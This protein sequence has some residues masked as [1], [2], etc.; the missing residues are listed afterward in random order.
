V[1]PAE[2]W[3]ALTLAAGQSGLRGARTALVRMGSPEAVLGAGAAEL[4]TRCGLK[5]E[6]A[7]RIANADSPTFRIESRLIAEHG[8]RLVPWD[9]PAYPEALRD[10]PSAP[11]LLYVQG[12]WPDGGSA[13]LGSG[14]PADDSGLVPPDRA[15][16]AGSPVPA[17]GSASSRR[18]APAQGAKPARGLTLAVVG[19]R[20][21]TGYGEQMTRALIAALARS[22][23]GLTVLSGLARGIDGIAHEAALEA[24][25]RTVAVLGNG[26]SRVYPP[27]HEALAARVRGHGALLSEFP[28]TAAPL[29]QN[30]PVRNRIIAG[31]AQ[32]VL[33]VE[34]GEQSGS[35]ITAGLAQAYGRALLAL[36]ANADQRESL[37]T[38]RLLQSR[39]ARL[40]LEPGD[41]LAALK[42]K[43]P[44][45]LA[46]GPVRPARKGGTAKKARKAGQDSS[47]RGRAGKP[48]APGD[49]A[50]TAVQADMPLPEGPTGR[51]LGAL[52]SG[53]QHP[54]ELAQ[55]AGLSIEQAL[56]LLLELE[57]SG[58]IVQTADHGYA[59][60]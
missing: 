6:L 31:L 57:L 59:L 42:G 60:P 23:P 48:G 25:L 22:E 56:G 5:A 52:R 4:E 13:P 28:M 35:L 18:L 54:D 15:A 9:D 21:P 14:P 55:A 39:Q 43:P 19:T 45:P 30:F 41:I 20:R 2:R 29:P 47:A 50:R 3:L 34:A 24:G 26:L 16:P 58:E 44:E 10:L 53:P 17:D 7:R 40:V 38:N 32:A 46:K 27:E 51:I 37:G 12:Q 36:P 49:S 11:L 33:I 8:V 1:T